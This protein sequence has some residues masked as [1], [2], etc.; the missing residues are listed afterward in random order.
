MFKE[1]PPN[2]EREY[3]KV[4]DDA[5]YTKGDYKKP[6]YEQVTNYKGW[7]ETRRKQGK[8]VPEKPHY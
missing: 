6:C 3:I 5:Q 4:P 8:W 1:A 7:I 2:E